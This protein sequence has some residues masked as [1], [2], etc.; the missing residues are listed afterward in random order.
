MTKHARLATSIAAVLVLA[1]ALSL[2]PTTVN[3]APD[4]PV[5]EPAPAQPKAPALEDIESAIDNALDWLRDHQH[6]DGSWDA[7]TYA[8]AGAA[9]EREGD[10]TNADGTDDQ[11]GWAATRVGV[12]AWAILAYLGDGHTHSEGDYRET[13]K[14]GLRYLRAV[15]D[16]DGCFGPRDDSYFIICHALATTAFGEAYALTGSAILKGP[17]QRGV[18]FLLLA[19]NADG[20]GRHGWRYGI[21]PGDNDTIVTGWCAMALYT[22]RLAELEVPV[23]AFEGAMRWIEDVTDPNTNITGFITRGGATAR[24]SVAADFKANPECEAVSAVLRMLLPG[25][26]DDPVADQLEHIAGHLPTADDALEVDYYYWYWG[27]LATALGKDVWKRWWPTAGTTLL[28]MQRA[29]E[30]NAATFG[31]WDPVDAWSPAFGRVYATALNTLSLQIGRRI[32]LI[33][34]RGNGDD[35]DGD[36]DGGDDNDGE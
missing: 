6:E 29:D 2:P 12:T 5:D 24:L 30:E 26:N 8:V 17:T 16:N 27:T 25:A 36:D 34:D 22:A 20:R 35:D 14:T 7:A 32:G 31:S 23:E 19:Q 10:Y 13:V 3:A 9:H 21:K 18:D 28:D 1:L 15:Q 33:G 4:D 11:P